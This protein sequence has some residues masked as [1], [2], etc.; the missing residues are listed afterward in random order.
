ML[1]RYISME[2]AL[3]RNWLGNP[4]SG[5][6]RGW[7]KHDFVLLLVCVKKFLKSLE[8]LS[9]SATDKQIDLEENDFRVK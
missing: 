1:V 5:S 2:L 3:I 8:L 6:L 4:F 7:E 9:T